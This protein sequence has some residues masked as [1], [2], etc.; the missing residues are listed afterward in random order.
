MSLVA[1]GP[2]FLV[3]TGTSNGQV[4]PRLSSCLQAPT[5]HSRK[6]SSWLEAA[7]S[8]FGSL[9]VCIALRA[10][11]WWGAAACTNHRLDV[12]GTRRKPSGACATCRC[13]GSALDASSP[14]RVASRAAP[15]AAP[16]PSPRS[17]QGRGESPSAVT[18]ACH[19]VCKPRRT[20]SVG[21]CAA[22][23]RPS[24]AGGLASLDS[25]SQSPNHSVAPTHWLELAFH[26]GCLPNSL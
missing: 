14:S 10:I 25:A 6:A 15:A 13:A 2:A 8:V 19:F 22:V 12:G 16:S 20:A 18:G 23:S 26:A 1:S 11:V 7:Y 5:R 9:N 21:Y 24:P 17:S 4:E 3:L